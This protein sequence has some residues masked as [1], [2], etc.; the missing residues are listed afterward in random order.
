M[1]RICLSFFFIPPRIIQFFFVMA[2]MRAIVAWLTAATAATAANLDVELAEV[3]LS[4]LTSEC[5]LKSAERVR[6]VNNSIYLMITG[7]VQ[8]D[9]T[10]PDQKPSKGHPVFFRWGP[11]ICEAIPLCIFDIFDIC[12]NHLYIHIY[13]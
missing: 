10:D 8:F 6:E 3:E 11:K 2:A 12:C 1:F 13:T 9:S 5:H 7:V 4:S